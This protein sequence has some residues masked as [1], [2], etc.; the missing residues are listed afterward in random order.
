MQ[1]APF[2]SKCR[3]Q[4]FDYDFWSWD[5]EEEVEKK[6]SLEY[7]EED[8]DLKET[9]HTSKFVFQTVYSKIEDIWNRYSM[10]ILLSSNFYQF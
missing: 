5:F 6:S 8:F 10:R 7:T 1:N 9:N 2:F 4:I 3:T